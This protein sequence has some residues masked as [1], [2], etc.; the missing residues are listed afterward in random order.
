[1]TIK[2]AKGYKKKCDDLVR[3]LTLSQSYCSRCRSTSYLQTS[4]IIGRRYSATRTDLS[5]LQCLCAKCHRRLTDFPR[6]FSQW[7][8]ESIGAKEYERLRQKAEWFEGKM[9]WEEELIRLKQFSV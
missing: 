3:K 4:H 5:N 6:E 8:T 9:N 1:M 2:S 7:I